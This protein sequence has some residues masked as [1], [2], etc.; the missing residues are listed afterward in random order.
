MSRTFSIKK[1]YSLEEKTWLKFYSGYGKEFP[2]TPTLS[3][4]PLAEVGGRL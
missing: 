1:G 2:H 4:I 3:S